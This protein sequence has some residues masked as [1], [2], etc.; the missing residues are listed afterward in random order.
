MSLTTPRFPLFKVAILC[1]TCATAT[2]QD[3]GRLLDQ[4]ITDATAEAE[5]GFEM[6]HDIW[7][8]FGDESVQ[9][10]DD[11]FRRAT[12]DETQAMVKQLFAQRSTNVS[13]E[14]VH[15]V[16][17][18]AGDFSDDAQDVV[19][20]A[21]QLPAF[22]EEPGES[23]VS[24]MNSKLI[25]QNAKETMYLDLGIIMDDASIEGAERML[26]KA[27]Q[28]ASS[29]NRGGQLELRVNVVY[30]DSGDFGVIEVVDFD[31]SGLGGPN[32]EIKIDTLTSTHALQ[33]KSRADPPYRPLSIDNGVSIADLRGQVAESR[34]LN[35][36]PVFVSN[37]EI[38]DDVKDAVTNPEN[39]LF[40]QIYGADPVPEADLIVLVPNFPLDP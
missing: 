21:T 2:G 37:A 15:R 5:L 27:G 32:G 38:A 13:P 14:R 29:A 9:R 36:T 7:A 25:S 1:L 3:C 18:V 35:R 6:L 4:W 12:P 33:M 30:R 23:I 40:A 28:S 26:H 10:I 31:R 11:F 24:L 34:A 22:V 16:L 19:R 39:P 17:E 8:D 20:R